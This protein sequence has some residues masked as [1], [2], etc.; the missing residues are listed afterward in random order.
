MQLARSSND[1]RYLKGR[2]KYKKV[3]M[4]K[5]RRNW[6]ELKSIFYRFEQSVIWVQAVFFLSVFILKVSGKEPDGDK[7]KQSDQ[8]M[9]KYAFHCSKN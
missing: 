1:H 8:H 4:G 7:D 2:A 6:M 9:S 5:K 3:T